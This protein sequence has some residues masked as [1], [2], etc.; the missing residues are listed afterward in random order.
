MNDEF[1][2]NSYE[3]ILLGEDSYRFLA[4]E[5]VRFEGS[6][7]QLFYVMTKRFGFKFN[8]VE[9]AVLE[10]QKNSHSHAHFSISRNFM[11]TFNDEDLLF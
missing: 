9:E 7:A 11:F 10:M 5:M 1:G 3:V 8:T 4:S 6:L 2:H